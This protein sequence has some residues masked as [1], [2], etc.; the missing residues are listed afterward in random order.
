LH[1]SSGVPGVESIGV[2]RNRDEFINNHHWVIESDHFLVVVKASEDMS[3]VKFI[4]K[5]ET[6]VN[7]ITRSSVG[8]IQDE[9]HALSQT[10]VGIE[11]LI[12]NRVVGS[13]GQSKD[14]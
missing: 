1:R 4:S 6:F 13:D 14:C 7:L 9:S 12:D 8:I 10:S 5:S 3:L 11:S 2:S